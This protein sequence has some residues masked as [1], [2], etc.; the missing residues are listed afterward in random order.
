MSFGPPIPQNAMETQQQAVGGVIKT[1]PVKLIYL[2]LMSKLRMLN[3]IL[4]LLI[5]IRA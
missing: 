3:F 5:L 1:L 4:I 2:I